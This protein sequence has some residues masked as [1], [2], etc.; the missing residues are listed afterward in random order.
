MTSLFTPPKFES[1]RAGAKLT[2]SQ[3]GTSTLQNTYQDVALTTPHANPVV[4]DSNGVFAPIYLDPTLPNYRVTYTTSA[5]VLVYQVDGVPSNQGVQQSLRL[6]STAPSV[7]L[8]D[9]DGTVNQRKFEV[10]ASGN[11]FRVDM[12]NDAEAVRTRL[13]TAAA[14]VVDFPSTAT[15]GSTAIA[16]TTGGSFTGTLTGMTAGTTGTVLYKRVGSLCYLYTTSAITG[17][18]NTTAMTMTGLPAACQAAHAH[19]AWCSVTDNGNLLMACQASVLNGTVTF[20]LGKTSG[21]ANFLQYSATNFTNSG[22][23][24]IPATWAIC[25]LVD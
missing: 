16:T 23:K 21:V 10:Y 11:E 13:F 14:G 25:Y 20:Q 3:T 7:F 4:A 1:T 5:D 8:Y 2:F 12:L 6:Q 19:D 18:S 17:T 24:G 22:T 15:I 9:T